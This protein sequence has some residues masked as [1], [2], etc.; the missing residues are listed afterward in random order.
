MPDTI[1]TKHDLCTGCN[2]CVRDCP[3]ETANI[4]YQDEDGNIKVKV[5]DIKC[6]ACGRCLSAC[7][8]DA[9]Y[10]EDDT[11]LFFDDLSKGVPISVVAAPSIRVNIPEYKRLF[12]F[13]KKIGVTRV[14]D[15]SLGADICMWAHVRYIEKC[16]ANPIITQSCPAIVS[17][18]EKYR[19]D[20]IEYLSPIQSPLACVS[21]YMKEHEGITD[22][23]AAL[24]PCLAKS[25]EFQDLELAQYNV[26]FKK[27]LLYIEENNIALPEE[28]TGFDHCKSGLGSIFPMPGGL[29]ENIE[30]FMG[31]TLRIDAFDGK[32]A[33]Q[34]LD[35]YAETEK[36]F[37]PE[38]FDVL[39]CD[40]GCNEG[41]A[42]PM[43]NNYFETSSV[44]DTC[45]KIATSDRGNEY[46]ERLYREYDNTFELSHYMRKYNPVDMPLPQ[47]TDEDI[48]KAFQSLNK[49]DD[50]RRNVDCNA[51]GSDTCYE[52][53][54]KI[55]LGVNI[56]VNCLVKSRDD[57]REEREKNLA[58]H[59]AS[60]KQIKETERQRRLLETTEQ[61]NRAKSAFLANMSHEMRTPMNAIIGMSAIGMVTG[62]VERKDECL[63]KINDASKHLLG[64]INDVLDI[65]KIES[66]K[67]EIS[68]VEFDFEKM[69]QQIVTVISFRVEEKRQK[70]KVYVDQAIP[71]FLVGDDQRITQ[72]IINLLGNA[73]KFTP[74]NG[75][76][77]LNTYFTGEENGVC[78]IRISV[79]DDGIGISA[80][81]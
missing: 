55:A 47:I 64:V 4:T 29:K 25:N 35:T 53:A 19:H 40:G 18:I 44:M 3:M 36:A 46:F 8:H 75:H 24:S 66:G 33:Y 23:I 59:Q 5:D 30:F 81:Q 67:F 1:K 73:V 22:R 34:K 32:D 12:M 15:V 28:A 63:S 38:V 9:R 20:L 6:I 56:P 76:I 45:R 48:E 68:P 62:E 2:R 61:A 10:Y 11:A 39:S 54:R 14:F 69:L 50:E 26:T 80:E 60:I 42:C 78:E 77:N 49:G 74:E 16:G 37:L 21:I 71:R 43:P 72:V 70:F 27:L 13:L 7:R 65:S 17:Y 52:M 31:K 51:C 41:P 58:G 57:A 79:S